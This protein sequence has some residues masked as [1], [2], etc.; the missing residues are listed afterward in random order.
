MNGIYYGGEKKQIFKKVDRYSRKKYLI[1]ILLFLSLYNIIEIVYNVLC[2]TKFRY[3][4]IDLLY[5]NEAITIK[6]ILLVCSMVN[7]SAIIA[8]SSFTFTKLKIDSSIFY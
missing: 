5:D 2:L 3:D 1:I 6:N 4:N 7:I 8:L